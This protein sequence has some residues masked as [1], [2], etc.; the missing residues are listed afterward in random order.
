MYLK[1]C[2]LGFVEVGVRQADRNGY[3]RITL[4]VKT[5]T[6]LRSGA[7]CPI[8]PTSNKTGRQAATGSEAGE[9]QQN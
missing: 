1:H 4:D 7:T 9:E 6:E 2:R 8:Q 5:L 3:V